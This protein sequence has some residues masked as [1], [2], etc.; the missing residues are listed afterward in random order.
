ML[1]ML[2]PQR[3]LV[4]LFFS[5]I[6]LPFVSVVAQREAAYP[7][8]FLIF[9]ETFRRNRGVHPCFI[10]IEGLSRSEVPE[11]L[12]ASAE[13]GEVEAGGDGITFGMTDLDSGGIGGEGLGREIKFQGGTHGAAVPKA[14][15]SVEGVTPGKGRGNDLVAVIH[16]D[17]EVFPE[18][19]GARNESGR[20]IWIR[21]ESAIGCSEI[22][23]DSDLDELVLAEMIKP[24]LLSAETTDAV[25]GELG[26]LR[27]G[28]EESNGR[29][30][31]ACLGRREKL[32]VVDQERCIMALA[33][34]VGFAEGFIG[35]REIEGD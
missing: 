17:S 34:E 6:G 24:G 9:A 26:Q 22:D 27:E 12:R 16:L 32:D 30:V 18:I 10:F 13:A 7:L 11:N 21:D 28:S 8:Y 35:Q 14:S 20:A 31:G 29:D 23:F 15:A 4:S 19:I 3:A 5:I 25:I 1:V 33:E 2:R